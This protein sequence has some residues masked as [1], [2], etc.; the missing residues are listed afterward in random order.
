MVQLFNL[1]YLIL[2]QIFGNMAQ[3]KYTVY[4]SGSDDEGESTSRSRF[5]VPE[6]SD[7]ETE[8]SSQSKGSFSK[9]E[10]Q[11]KELKS[12]LLPT[13]KI[14]IASVDKQDA[15]TSP[16]KQ[17]KGPSTVKIEMATSPVM[18]EMATSLVK[19]EV[20]ASSVN[21]ETEFQPTSRQK[22]TTE[23]RDKV[24]LVFKDVVGY[25]LRYSDFDRMHGSNSELQNVVASVMTRYDWDYRRARDSV[26][27]SFR[28]KRRSQKE[29]N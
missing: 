6:S 15:N 23:E 2:A 18:C 26:I 16:F 4:A 27:Q 8:S 10:K 7:E 12:C 14:D 5:S 9:N 11:K 25:S 1:V 24:L 17:E 20:V 3:R 13:C 19:E 22:L 28:G 21:Q 29:S